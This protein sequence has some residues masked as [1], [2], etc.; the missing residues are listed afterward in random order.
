MADRH[1]KNKRTLD[2]PKEITDALS[3]PPIEYLRN[4]W[5]ANSTDEERKAADDRDATIE[6]AYEFI[7]D[8]SRRA[9]H[10]NGACLPDQV[11]Y[12][13]TGI[14]M[15][16]CIDGDVYATA[17]EI[18][19]DEKREKEAA[20]RE[21]KRKAEAE[22]RREEAAKKEEERLA[23]LSPEEREAYEKE[24]AERAEKDEQA[25]AE[26]EAQR[27][28]REAEEKIKREKRE[29]AARKKALAEEMKK[30]QMTFF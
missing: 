3:V 5:L 20:E 29:A 13:L 1:K 26:A 10:K 24:K 11:V 7:E 19:E 6:G 18:A 23:A 21:A 28:A 30:R 9:K 17:E 2:I 25:K 15:R 16:M 4:W 12:D 8:F 22:K 27:K 14:F